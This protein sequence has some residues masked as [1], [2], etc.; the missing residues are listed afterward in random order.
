MNI[1][2]KFF[3][4]KKN[5]YN[6]LVILFIGL[7]LI[8]VGSSFFN[9]EKPKT[10]QQTNSYST[11][12]DLK[13]SYEENL[14]AKLEETLSY[15]YGVGKVKVMISFENGKEI[16]TKND[17]SKETSDIVEEA[18]NG[19][20]RQTKNYNQSSTTV[21]IDGDSPLIVK[22]INPKIL[23]VV[24]VAEG[25]GDINVKNNLINA[26]KALLNVDIHKIEV[27]KMR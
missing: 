22:E 11:I 12:N 23:G 3:E 15:V 8:F 1:L 26:T 4:D 19:D 14:E 6:F 21:K 16:V 25:G 24:I 13:L 7:L 20:K 5:Y 9:I 2:R 17:F 10:I 27:L 18:S